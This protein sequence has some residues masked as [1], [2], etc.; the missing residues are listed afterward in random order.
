[1]KRIFIMLISLLLIACNAAA[2]TPKDFQA[3]REGNWVLYVPREGFTR[4]ELPEQ[5][6][7]S[8]MALLGVAE[9]GS[10]N[11]PLNYSGYNVALF[12]GRDPS[13]K[14]M[15]PDQEEQVLN[16]VFSSMWD[17]SARTSKIATKKLLYKEF[18][19]N[20]H[21]HKYLRA[22]YISEIP[23]KPK[24]DC[25]CITGIY[26]FGDTAYMLDVSQNEPSKMPHTFEMSLLVNWF[27]AY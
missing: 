26:I 15:R 12:Y 4:I 17:A 6:A 3:I 19:T 8:G 11:N 5:S 25:T 2:S 16:N 18:V 7:D 27:N 14:S 23:N 1:M 22:V 24:L 13:L 10:N 21:G 9:R 20:T